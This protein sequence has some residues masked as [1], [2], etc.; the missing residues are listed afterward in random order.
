MFPCSQNPLSPLESRHIERGETQLHATKLPEEMPV[1]GDKVQK[2]V[3][4]YEHEKTFK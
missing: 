1:L 3:H 4:Q 2:T